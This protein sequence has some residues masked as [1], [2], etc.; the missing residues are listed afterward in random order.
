MEENLSGKLN[1]CVGGVIVYG[2]KALG[3]PLNTCI[4]FRDGRGG[5]G[6]LLKL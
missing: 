5:G 6:L 3:I 2:G 1:V 4:L